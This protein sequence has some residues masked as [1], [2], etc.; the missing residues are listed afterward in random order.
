MVENQPVSRTVSVKTMH[1]TLKL[2]SE[3][4]FSYLKLEGG[5]S[6]GALE[7]IGS[8]LRMLS[9]EPEMSASLNEWFTGVFDHAA[10]E[11]KTLVAQK[12]VFA[13]MLE[14]EVPNIEIPDSFVFDIEITHPAMWQL[15]NLLKKIDAEL[16][17]M[18]GMWML[19][20]VTDVELHQAR[21]QALSIV[22]RTIHK[23]FE[24]TSPGKRAEGGK[25][26]PIKFLSIVRKEK[27]MPS[28]DIETTTPRL[29]E[30]AKQEII[31]SKASDI[32]PS[33]TD[34][35]VIAADVDADLSADVHLKK[36][37]AKITKAG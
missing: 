29:I 24:M 18:E 9:K 15:I 32:E 34:D 7:R 21:N 36:A 17:D 37:K 27:G 3:Q 8:L 4:L 26:S 35:V 13:E 2:N 23:I 28:R 33:D 12:Q 1:Y 14:M 20:A 30:P 22:R 31:K 6:V 11:M 19:G 25:F 10:K 5:K 16:D